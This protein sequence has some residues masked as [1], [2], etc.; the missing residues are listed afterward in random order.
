MARKVF[1]VHHLHIEKGFTTTSKW[2]H[3]S[4]HLNMTRHLKD[5]YS[6]RK[7][8]NKKNQFLTI[9]LYNRKYLHWITFNSEM[10]NQMHLN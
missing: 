4:Q 5:L 3:V 1:I 2:K 10:M 8:Q 7:K 6:I 9:T